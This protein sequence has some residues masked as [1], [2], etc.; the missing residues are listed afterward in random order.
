MSATSGRA[1]TGEICGL[2]GETASVTAG[3]NLTIPFG[4]KHKNSSSG[5]SK[6]GLKFNAAHQYE[7][8]NLDVASIVKTDILDFG[9]N[10]DG[11]T[12]SLMLAGQN[13]SE[14]SFSLLEHQPPG[15]FE[16]SEIA[17][18]NTAG[19]IAIGAGAT[20]VVVAVVGVGLILTHNGN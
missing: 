10:L 20:I 6:L 9:I 18:I 13:W 5:K 15:D 19:K 8:Q 2:H 16:G 1:Q 4:A 12:S 17:S 7:M 3:I 14:V 11:G